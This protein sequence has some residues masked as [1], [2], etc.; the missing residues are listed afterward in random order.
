MVGMEQHSICYGIGGLAKKPGST[1][2]M[3]LTN[4]GRLALC[5]GETGNIIKH[6][7][8][9]INGAKYCNSSVDFSKDGKN[10][11]V[12]I[13]GD[14][15]LIIYDSSLFIRKDQWTYPKYDA[16]MLARWISNTRILA[17]YAKPGELM[18][19]AL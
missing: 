13:T 5:N 18:V 16:I 2:F 19:F 15:E 8:L 17:G 9:E 11:L 7:D 1:E 14:K 10:F 3:A 6:L 12:S 4:H